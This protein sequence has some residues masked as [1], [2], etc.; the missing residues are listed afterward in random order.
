MSAAGQG[1]FQLQSRSFIPRDAGTSRDICAERYVRVTRTGF[2]GPPM[3]VGFPFELR[4]VIA[5]L[6]SAAVVWT[7][8]KN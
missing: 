7:G 1:P 3:D 4:T 5:R 6:K 2:Y 8:H